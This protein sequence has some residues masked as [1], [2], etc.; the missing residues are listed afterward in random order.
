MA[1]PAAVFRPSLLSTSLACVALPGWEYPFPA[2][3]AGQPW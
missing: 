1:L 2:G 3:P